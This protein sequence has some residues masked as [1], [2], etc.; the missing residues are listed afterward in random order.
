MVEETTLPLAAASSWDTLPSEKQG[1]WKTLLLA[2]EVGTGSHTFSLSFANPYC[3]WTG[4]ECLDQRKLYVDSVTVTSP[5]GVK[6]TMRGSDPR[7]VT[8]YSNG[9]PDCYSQ[10]GGYSV[11]FNGSLSLTMTITEPGRYIFESSLSAELAPSLEGYVEVQLAIQAKGDILK[12]TTKTAT[13]IKEQISMLFERLHGTIKAANSEQVMQVY[14]IYAAA[15]TAEQES[16][17][18]GW[19]FENCD[20]YH[21]GFF[22]EENFTAEEVASFRITDSGQNWYD[23]DWDALGPLTQRITA[24]PLSSKYAWTAV[25]MYMLSHYD[26]VHE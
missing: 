20:L 8:S 14:E 17:G 15:L 12:A 1:D 16:D 18:S 13:A 9:N 6:Q 10:S 23:Y 24:D 4:T 3:N 25:M 5:S 19:E 21:D 22:Y 26:Y 11:C 7:L 2:G